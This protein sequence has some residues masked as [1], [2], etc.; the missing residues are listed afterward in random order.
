MLN[1]HSTELITENVFR[2]SRKTESSNRI[3]AMLQT[4]LQNF[5]RMGLAEGSYLGK[6]FVLDI[7]IKC[8]NF[9]VRVRNTK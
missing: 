8:E 3:L 1:L 6:M 5:N 7:E 4:P 9:A 2:Q